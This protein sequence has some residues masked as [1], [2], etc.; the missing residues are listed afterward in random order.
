M[1]KS[2]RILLF[3]AN[4]Y[5]YFIS[6][7]LALAEAAMQEGYE[8]HVALPQIPQLPSQLT[9]K[10]TFHPF[11]LRRNSISV[12]TELGTLFSLYQLCRR[13]KPDLMHLITAKPAIYGGLVSKL[14]KIKSV[15]YLLPGLGYV[16]SANS[17]KARLLRMLIPFLNKIA[18]SH[19]NGCLV[20]QNNDDQ[21]FY[22]KTK[23]IK[24]EN[25]R[26]IYGSGVDINFFTPDLIDSK[27]EP[28]SGVIIVLAAR[29]LWEKGVAEFVE[30]AKLLK[31][32]QSTARF[33]LVGE[34]D[35]GNP[36][37]IP[38]EQL[39]Q[40]KD[41]GVVEWWGKSQDMREVFAKADIVC[42][43]S[44]YGEGLPKVLLEAA[45]CAKPIITTDSPG[46]REIVR[47]QVNG[48]LIPIKNIE[49]LV[50]ALKI[51]INDPEKRKKFGENGRRIVTA[52]FS[53]DKINQETLAVYRMLESR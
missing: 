22:I 17:L 28:N 53:I 36:S 43:P 37:A 10:F 25:T 33:A 26:V 6:H 23:Q 13:L 20:L 11:S 39:H 44:Y 8:V 41:S 38:L 12:F 5:T 29:L 31:E 15:V 27:P 19:K 2:K 14:V 35:W 16:F 50:T 46:C 18:L 52:E 45:A 51:L 48:I 21:N 3:V 30:A 32:Q 24:K 4:D 40:W 34:P 9:S 7:R 49:A 42:L 1:Q 47:D